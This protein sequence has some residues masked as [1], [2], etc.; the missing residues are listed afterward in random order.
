VTFRTLNKCLPCVACGLVRVRHTPFPG[1]SECF[2]AILLTRGVA[3][4]AGG[5][6]GYIPPNQST[7][8]FF[9]WLFCLFDPGQIRYRAIYTHPNQIP[10]YASVIDFISFVLTVLLT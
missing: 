10:G 7:L 8:N 5:I 1:Q 9:M 3:T 2:V 6:S 4:G